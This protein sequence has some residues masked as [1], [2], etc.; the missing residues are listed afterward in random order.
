MMLTNCTFERGLLKRKRGIDV[1]LF[2]RKSH[3]KK[4][5]LADMFDL[6]G[7]GLFKRESVADMF[8]LEMVIL[9]KNRSYTMVDRIYICF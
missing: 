4:K 6:G 7:E 5:N 9:I 8:V 2:E 3:F 1:T